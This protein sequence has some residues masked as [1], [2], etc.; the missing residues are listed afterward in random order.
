[1]V[2]VAK[3]T[4]YEALRAVLQHEEPT[5]IDTLKRDMERARMRA[6]DVPLLGHSA[7]VGD[8]RR[9]DARGHEASLLQ[10]AEASLQRPLPRDASARPVHADR[11]RLA[12][13][14]APRRV[15][16]ASC[17]LGTGIPEQEN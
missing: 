9:Q 12:P 10:P 3:L 6:E 7:L 5:Y 4:A 14:C 1:M 13:Q 11:L 17:P 15:P 2:S 16:C 8:G